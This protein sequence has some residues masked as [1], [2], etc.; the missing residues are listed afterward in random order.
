[1]GE[2]QTTPK[3]SSPKEQVSCRKRRQ[4]SLQDPS[5]PDGVNA[6]SFSH[7]FFAV[8]AVTAFFLVL[9]FFHAFFHKLPTC[10]LLCWG[11]KPWM[12]FWIDLELMGQ[13]WKMRPQWVGLA[14]CRESPVVLLRELRVL[15]EREVQGGRWG[16][17]GDPAGRL[18]RHCGG[19]E[20]SRRVC[21]LQFLKCEEACL[22]CSGNDCTTCVQHSVNR[23]GEGC[24]SLPT[25]SPAAYS[26]PIS[27]VPRTVGVNLVSNVQPPSETIW[28]GG[29]HFEAHS[30]FAPVTSFIK[31]CRSVFCMFFSSK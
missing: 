8:L 9:V 24:T 6:T 17:G 22:A 20:E 31:L 26:H 5:A 23:G 12:L 28:P 16:G 11:Q 14:L 2:Y 29:W 15:R 21:P 19:V 13:S 27:L 25:P 18:Q 30:T 1:M 7:C 3:G 10:H 4:K